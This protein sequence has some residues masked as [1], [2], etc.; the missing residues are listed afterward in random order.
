MKLRS[1][2]A[3]AVVSGLLVG[4][5]LAGVSERA[6]FERGALYLLGQYR[7]AVGDT[8]CGLELISR[9][10]TPRQPADKKVAP[11]NHRVSDQS[12]P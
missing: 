8:E 12:A 7:I 2:L 3:S 6:T 4:G 5:P 1:F 9:A 11:A 10:A